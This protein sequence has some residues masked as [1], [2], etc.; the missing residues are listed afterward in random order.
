MRSVRGQV[1]PGRNKLRRSP[2]SHRGCGPAQRTFKGAERFGNRGLGKGWPEQ[3]GCGPAESSEPGRSGNAQLLGEGGGRGHGR[4]NSVLRSMRQGRDA[5]AHLLRDRRRVARP[6][7]ATGLLPAAHREHLTAGVVGPRVAGGGRRLVGMGVRKGRRERHGLPEGRAREVN[8]AADRRVAASLLAGAHL[9]DHRRGALA[10]PLV[11]GETDLAAEGRGPL[12]PAIGRARAA[13]L[14]GRAPVGVLL[15]ASRG[16]G[17]DAS[18]LR[19][20]RHR[21]VGLPGRAHELAQEVGQASQGAPDLALERAAQRVEAAAALP[22][23]VVGPPRHEAVEALL[24]RSLRSLAAGRARAC[25]AVVGRAVRRAMRAHASVASHRGGAPPEAIDRLPTRRL[26]RRKGA[27]GL[28]AL[29]GGGG[30]LSDVGVE[31]ARARR[32]LCRG[33]QVHLAL[34]ERAHEV[35]AQGAHLLQAHVALE[36]QGAAHGLAQRLRDGAG[37]E[38]RAAAEDEEERGAGREEVRLGVVA[39][40]LQHLG[41]EVAGSAAAPLELAVRGQPRGEAEVGEH[42]AP[43]ATEQ[44]VLGLD[45]AVDH[46]APHVEVLEGAQEALHAAARAQLR[47]ARPQDGLEEAAA[48]AGLHHQGPLLRGI[49]CD[50]DAVE[51]D[52]VGVPLG[53]DQRVHLLAE[54]G[55]LLQAAALDGGLLEHLHDEAASLGQPLDLARGREDDGVGAGAQGLGHHRQ[56]V[57][58]VRADR[59][60]CGEQVEPALQQVGAAADDLQDPDL[61]LERQL[62]GIFDAPAQEVLARG[63]DQQRGAIGL[64][65]ANQRPDH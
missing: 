41:G 49:I 9:A 6:L 1:L 26:H 54:L 17:P 39:R 48:H 37:V 51:A 46:P 38:R 29:R 47:V 53:A 24:L 28:H 27:H 11:V 25:R 31:P 16:Q 50:E 65:I 43:I 32:L 30:A 34:H 2:A 58:E 22:A 57:L 36:V 12:L 13:H 8:L 64:A 5:L 59:A 18:L 3:K 42:R 19:R 45:I 56:R 4:L 23:T 40:V 35:L 14:V 21:L 63:C 60:C 33:A 7:G 10:L 44:D 62:L 15:D 55:L 61:Q 20:R 52:D